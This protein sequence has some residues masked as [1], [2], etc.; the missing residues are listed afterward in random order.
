MAIVLAWTALLGQSPRHPDDIV[1]AA[2]S[3]AQILIACAIIFTLFSIPRRPDVFRPDGRLVEREFTRSLL[4]WFTFSWSSDLLDVAGTK[5]IEVADLPS[6]PASVRSE[7]RIVAFRGGPLKPTVALWKLILWSFRVEFVMQW[8]LVILSTLLDVAPQYT[9][10]RLLQYLEARQ[11]LNKID[12]QAWLWVGT[13]LASTVS[14]T[15]VNNRITWFMY[16]RLAIPIRSILT[17][18]IFEKMMKIKDCKDPPKTE[19]MENTK[20]S[21]TDEVPKENGAHSKP[22]PKSRTSKGASPQTQ[23]DITNMFAVD[24]NLVGNFGAN[25][26]F[27][28]H[29]TSKIIVSITFLWLLVG[30]QSLFAGLVALA[31]MIPVNSFIAKRYRLNQ[32]ALMKARDAKTKVI[33]EALNGIRQIKFSA[34]ESQWAE[35]IYGVR[36]EELG[37]L[38]NTQKNNIL[39]IL[40][41]SIAPVLLVAFALSTY[42]YIHGELLPSVAFTALGVFMQLEGVLGMTPFLL[43]IGMNA[44]VSS[45]RID[46]F[47]Q[48]EERPENT[49]PG[50]SVVFD[51]ASVSFPSDSKE[52]KDDRFV[53]RNL[54]LQFPHNSLSVISG[55]T[56]S[57]KSLLLAAILGEIELLSG[58]IRVPR[59]P[60]PDK[61]YDSKATSDN[62]IL[63]AAIAFVSQTP[64]IENATIK[65]NVLFGLPLDTDRYNRVLEACALTKDLEMFEDGDSTEVGAQGISLSGGQKW[66]LTLARALYS[67]AGILILDD[68]FSAIDAHVGKEIYDN[69]LM[70]E[71]A[72][73]RTRILVTHHV[74]LCLPRAKYAVSLSAQGTIE[75]ASLVDELRTSGNLEEILKTDQDTKEGEDGES[76]EATLEGH[77]NGSGSKSTAKPDSEHKPKKLVEDEKRETGSVKSSVYLSYLTATGGFPFWT[78][79]L[80]FYFVSQGLT[81]SRSWWIK[82]W[83]SSYE[84]PESIRTHIAHAFSMQTQLITPPRNSTI[85]HIQPNNHAIGYYLAVYVGISMVSVLVATTRFLLVFRGSL[86]ASRRV[87]KSM[88]NCVLRTPLRWLDTEPTGRIL[89][90]FTADFQSMDSQLASELAQT[91]ASVVQILGIMAAA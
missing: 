79:V 43:V 9:I 81:L 15:L 42:A 83:T 56:G 5:V 58:S 2:M 17:T 27:Y 38:W 40:G 52:P 77:A 88:T 7:D 59:A 33:T 30:W 39:M 19:E 73:G 55:P 89:N 23:H 61:R 70:G 47:L 86:R 18:L 28:I 45:D 69:A 53:L 76:S 90:R 68:V 1:L 31:M 46:S 91:G 50:D 60:P 54:N 63:P 84:Q 24:A 49:Y 72:E 87:F 16:S 14:A 48:S 12:P 32:K 29:F 21:K 64:W 74:S 20:A 57:G 67:R 13:L 25:S 11:G 80:F 26:Q 10:M 35:K 36:E 71:L 85:L 8:F 4:A 66:R 78:I 41:S 44:K 3:V 6:L 34:T 37:K 62:W 82:I 22:I 65:N 51:D 75:H